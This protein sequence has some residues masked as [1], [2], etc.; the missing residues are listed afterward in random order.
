MIKRIA[1]TIIYLMILCTCSCSRI[2]YSSDISAFLNSDFNKDGKPE[3]IYLEIGE[4]TLQQFLVIEQDN[5]IFLKIPYFTH[6][7]EPYFNT[8]LAVIYREG[9]HYL[10]KHRLMVKGGKN[11]EIHIY[12]FQDD[13]MQ[14]IKP[15]DKKINTLK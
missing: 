6:Y 15:T 3:K 14:L 11:K 8:T 7:K 12:E 4:H 1:T 5:K 2:Y 9:D 10:P 13:K